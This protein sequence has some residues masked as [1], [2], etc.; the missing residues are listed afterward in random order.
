MRTA[1]LV[2]AAAL[3]A[4]LVAVAF[5]PA[6]ASGDGGRAVAVTQG[7]VPTGAAAVGGYTFD[8]GAVKL[9]HGAN[10]F[11][12]TVAQAQGS[13]CGAQPLGGPWRVWGT[14]IQYIDGTPTKNP[15]PADGTATFDRQGKQLTRSVQFPWFV[16][17][18]SLR[19]A[20]NPPTASVWFWNG[21][22]V[23]RQEVVVELKPNPACTLAVAVRSLDC[24]PEPAAAGKRLTGKAVVAVTRGG[25]PG[26]LAPSATVTWRAVVGGTRLRTLS[27]ARSG[28]VLRAT[29]KLP[30]AVTA[31]V[32]RVTV[33]V[34]TEGVV[35]T[36][37]HLH[38]VR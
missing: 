31:K 2:W 9:R 18:L 21:Q 38:R 23:S 20:E 34:A 15:M 22:A 24:T 27:T 37:T 30:K 1:A 5:V 7:V 13:Y 12:W 16:Q 26:A 4:S 3:A 10:D 8:T 28:G 6:G 14:Y 17:E 35:A 33:T 19:L 29:W 11:Y 32:V 25:T 36:K